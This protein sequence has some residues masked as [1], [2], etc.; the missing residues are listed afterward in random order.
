VSTGVDALSIWRTG[1]DRAGV[2]HPVISASFGD[3]PMAGYRYLDAPIVGLFGL[4]RRTERMVAALAGTGAI[5]ALFFLVRRVLDEAHAAAAVL[6]A[7]LCPTWIQFSRYG[8]EA[9]LLPLSLTLGWLAVEAGKERRAFLWIGAALLGSSAYTY[10]SVKLV[11][12][13]FVLGFLVYH[14]PLATELWRKGRVHFVGSILVFAIVVLP[15]LLASLSSEGQNR[16]RAVLAWYRFEGVNLFLTMMNN[17]LSYFD[18]GMLF[19]RGG[20]HVAQS[21]IGLGIWNLCELPFIVVG[22]SAM[23]RPGPHRRFFG[24]VLFLFL[25]GPLPGGI[26]YEMHNIGRVIGWL[27]APQIISAFGLVTSIRWILARPAKTVRFGL[28]ALVGAAWIATAGWVAYQAR[29]R[30]PNEAQRHWQHEIS[31]AM[32]CALVHRRDEVVVVSPRFHMATLFATFHYSDL[33]PMPDGSPPWRHGDPPV[34]E[35][36]QLYVV[37]AAKTPLPKGRELCRIVPRGAAAPVSFVFGPPAE[38]GGEPGSEQ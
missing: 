26:S 4:T 12:P 18:P 5:L 28:L 8:S 3:Y 31:D 29:V 1:K 37:P 11:L 34:V 24:F 2:P 17:Y 9:I 25:T 13:L 30:Y 14:R 27:P 23:L 36:G 20:P 32:K 15:P 22:L 21:I 16:Q 38:V 10:H 6:V 19:V 35:P 7:A 33:A